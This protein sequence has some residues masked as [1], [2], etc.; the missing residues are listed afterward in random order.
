MSGEDTCCG[1]GLPFEDADAEATGYLDTGIRFSLI[2][3]VRV[4]SYH[5]DEC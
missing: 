2:G 3:G 1:Y 5:A 4:I